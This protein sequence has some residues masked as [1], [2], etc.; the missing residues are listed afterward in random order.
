MPK[1]PFR[2]VVVVC[3]LSWIA[4]AALWLPSANPVLAVTLPVPYISQYTG[5][6]SSNYDCGHTTAAMVLEA[7]GLRPAGWS[8]A[9]FVW[10]VRNK[11][12]TSGWAGWWNMKASINAYGLEATE[13]DPFAPDPD[14]QLQSLK[15][16]VMQGKPVI[17]FVNASALGRSYQG[18]WIVVRGISPDGQT[19]EVNDP[20]D[21]TPRWDGWIP[22]GATTWSY[23][24]LRDAAIAT[25]Q[26][27][28]EGL[29]VGT[30]LTINVSQQLQAELV[31][32]VSNQATMV[33]GSTQ[34]IQLQFRNNGSLTWDTNTKLASIPADVPS[35]F[36]DPSWLGTTR[37]AT[38]GLVAPGGIVTL[39]VTIQAPATPGQ[40]KF[41]FAFVQEGVAWFSFPPLDYYW[42]PI[43]VTQAIYSGTLIGVPTYQ[44]SM[45][46]GATQVVQITV[47]NTGTVAWDSNTRLAPLPGDQASSLTDVSWQSSTR[48]MATGAVASGANKTLQ[49]TI[50]APNTPGTYKQSFGLVQEAVAW[51]VNPA[52]DAINLRI[53]VTMPT[54]YSGTLVE[55]LNYQGGMVAGTTQV[56]QVTIRNT[57]TASWDS[58]TRLSPLPGDQSSALADTSWQSLTR[59]MAAGPVA[60]GATKTFQFTIKAP[61]TPGTYKQSFGLVQEAVTWFADPAL[62][63]INLRITVTA[64]PLATQDLT[65]VVAT[66][67][68]LPG[69][70]GVSVNPTNN[71][72]YVTALPSD[73]LQIINGATNAVI[74]TTTVGPGPH[75]VAVNPNTN[76]IYIT[77]NSGSTL[78]V[79]DGVSTKV[80]ATITGLSDNPVGVAVDPTHNRI[81][82]AY[83][84]SK[85]A[86]IEGGTNTLATTLDT[87][88]ANG[89]VAINEATNRAYVTK[90]APGTVAVLDLA[91]NQ[92]LGDIVTNG[93]LHGIAVN[94]Q[95]NRV[96]AANNTNNTLSVI[97]GATATLMTAVSVGTAPT[98]VAV[99]PVTNCI[100]VANAGSN[101]VSIV[102]GATNQVV[103]TVSV[104]LDPKSI[105][106][107]T[108]TGFVYVA[109]RGSNTVS[110]IRDLACNNAPPVGKSFN[111][112]VYV[113]VYDPMLSNGQLLSR[114]LGWN[115]HATL[116]QG[117]INFFKAVTNNRLNYTVAYTTVLTDGWPAKLDGFRYTEQE[118]LN[119]VNGITQ[120]HKPDMVDYTQVVNTAGLDI[121]GKV[122]RGEI[123]ELW[124]YNGPEFGFYESLLVGP[125]GYWFNSP[126][127]TTG[128]TCNRLLPVMG[129]SPQVNL[130]NTIHNFG[131]R[132]EST[133]WHVYG[134]WDQRIP[135]RHNW[136]RFALSQ[137][138]T[139]GA[140]PYSGCGDLH[141]PPTAASG[142]DYTNSATVLSTCEDFRHYPNLGDPAVMVQ[143]TTC[144]AWGCDALG[145]YA[146]WFGHLPSF[147]GCGPDGY[148]NDWWRYVAEPIVALTPTSPCQT[149]ATPTL[150]LNFA[151]GR[152]GSFFTLTGANFPPNGTVTFRV[153]ATTLTTQLPTDGL[154]SFSLLLDTTGASNGRYMVNIN[155]STTT[156]F[157]LDPAEPLRTQASAGTLLKLPSGLGKFDVFLPVLSNR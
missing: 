36:A 120:A 97:D 9:D 76:Q 91:S 134:T 155:P 150:T 80:S 54:I 96:F 145:Y 44:T 135:P 154:G 146:Y 78:T 57:G 26:S 107:N 62:D 8:D 125:N 39:N 82:A 52:L 130:D 117:T 49:F 123:D 53:T 100:Y 41:A 13:F 151:T 127:L 1:L 93:S 25:P 17:L 105:A 46:A 98:D 104:G 42:L 84:G 22:G 58:N 70:H 119:V 121:C 20:D 83:G 156:T 31:N 111:K 40:Y 66:I 48:V 59:V 148:A 136:E 149:T 2:T 5:L 67:P 50:K 55:A 73:Q 109:N 143:P 113:L 30:G 139:N 126:P 101:T 128:T 115:D 106:V 60:S 118:Y 132:A 12:G 3:W 141:F 51:F 137:I 133:L 47:R 21:Q 32:S 16:A 45:V 33:A 88:P 142:Y 99:N 92:R 90:N 110:V 37:I 63:A 74:A 131:H 38:T 69:P 6:A 72:I 75:S 114:R 14:V 56:V 15:D 157:V 68:V 19:V 147:S 65:R 153:N 10:D 79:V 108:V 61:S 81:F 102:S 34:V 11:S 4:G 95:T 89:Y 77:N 87:G 71:R 85:L 124:V 94:A 7:Y 152:A 122:N 28:I 23:A 140:T 129:P 116:T 144:A 35:P 27:G 24:T 43:T 64:P 29:I 138:N 86:V 103:G 18:H 112:K